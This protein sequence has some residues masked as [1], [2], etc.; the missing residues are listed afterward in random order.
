MAVVSHA[1]G[2]KN[3][4]PWPGSGHQLSCK[5]VHLLS[6][7]FPWQTHPQLYLPGGV[8]QSAKYL[9]SFMVLREQDIPGSNV[10][11]HKPLL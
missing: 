7:W 9:A 4:T 6:Q 5:V 11:V 8:N 2:S 3:G 10:P 1:F